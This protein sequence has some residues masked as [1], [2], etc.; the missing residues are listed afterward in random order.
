MK[1]GKK[2][3]DEWVDPTA[4][5]EKMGEAAAVEG[6]L[7]YYFIPNLIEELSDLGVSVV[8][9]EKPG[10]GSP[11]HEFSS[12]R[13]FLT[14]A[15]TLAYEI[16]VCK[17]QA[18]AWRSHLDDLS[19]KLRGYKKKVK[20]E[21]DKSEKV[22]DEFLRE[23]ADR[24]AKGETSI[25]EIIAHAGVERSTGYRYIAVFNKWIQKQASAIKKRQPGITQADLVVL[26]REKFAT[27]A[28]VNT[29]TIRRALKQR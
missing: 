27:S 19:N 1:K 4:P 20:K 9:V 18:R 12:D 25:R 5:T 17:E 16:G 14:K 6:D 23:Y 29:E 2:P 11:R 7:L 13:K 26:L 10:D 15:V 3:R 24:I 21:R 22:S 8:L 28:G